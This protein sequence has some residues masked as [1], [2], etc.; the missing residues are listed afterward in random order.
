MSD[1]YVVDAKELIKV[2]LGIILTR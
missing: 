1:T 2:E